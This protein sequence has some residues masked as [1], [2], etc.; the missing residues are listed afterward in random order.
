MKSI[1][2]RLFLLG[3]F[4][5]VLISV[6]AYAR[7][8]R[9]NVNKKSITPTGI[10]VASSF[11]DGAKIYVNGK[12]KG[13]T[14]T[15]IT[16]VPDNYDVEIKKDGYRP[17]RKSINVKG[18]IVIKTDSLLFPQNPSLSPLTSL[19]VIN[20]KYSPI[21]NRI[22]FV[23]NSPDAEK[24]GI[25]LLDNSRRA[26]SLFN[27]LRLVV[28]KSVLPEDIDYA[29]TQFE[30]SPDGK[31][32]LMNVCKA[33]VV[34]D[35]LITPS[36]T[37]TPTSTVPPVNCD[38]PLY[39][40]LIAADNEKQQP[41][42]ITR[43]ETAIRNA[44]KKE[45][46]KNILKI[47]ETF[48]DPIPQMATDSVRILSFSPDDSKI[49]YKATKDVT[50]PLI[51]NPPLI[52]ANQG[53]ETRTLKKDRIY[54][55]DKKEDKNYEIPQEVQT[56]SP[57]PSPVTKFGQI[58]EPT[59]D[60]SSLDT[61]QN[62]IIWYPDSRHLIINESKRVSIIDYDGN[63]RQTVYSG[64][65]DKNFLGVS[66]EGNLLILANLNPGENQYPDVY[67]VGIR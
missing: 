26:L 63:T 52:G 60:V 15:N 62:T 36:P 41:L 39:S 65:F 10:L 21:T 53:K 47:I 29:S 31:Q 58:G 37:P 12:L 44:W 19:G 49:L 64:P 54:V 50:I 59:L 23:S 20:A 51:I 14:N 45:E 38:L 1:F 40:F 56:L 11:P 34:V 4:I 6:I 2:I 66:S 57:T 24:D 9:L 61:F 27:P 43:S 30:F 13:A 17:W 16:L 32:I 46:D 42:N 28:L 8:Y 67:T 7:G 48:K 3:I 5:G 22:I 25:Y 33:K 35:P 55:Y 18:E